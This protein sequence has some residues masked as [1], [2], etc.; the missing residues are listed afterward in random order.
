MPTPTRHKHDPYDDF[1]MGT[2]F[3]I[4]SR[5]QR[6]YVDFEGADYR[7]HMADRAVS[8]RFS[9][10]PFDALGDSPYMR[11]LKAKVRR[12]VNPEDMIHYAN[13]YFRECWGPALH[14]RTGEII[15]DKGGKPVLV[16]REPYTIGGFCLALGI[17]QGNLNGYIKRAK[18]G[19]IDPDFWIVISAGLDII[20]AFAEKMLYDRDASQGAKFVLQSR[21]NWLTPKEQAEIRQIR[22]K[23]SLAEREMAIKEQMLHG[24]DGDSDIKIEIVRKKE[25]D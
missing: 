9:Q 13:L 12:Y 20:Q 10:I 25:N 15:Y 16:Q 23:M 4:K 21:Y 17:Q 14:K 18:E 24:V 6:I 22:A 3:R 1:F 11:V 2:N 8:L 19:K 5:G 7:H